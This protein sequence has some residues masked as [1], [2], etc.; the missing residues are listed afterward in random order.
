MK[1]AMLQMLPYAIWIL[2]FCLPPSRE[3]LSCTCQKFHGSTL[4]GSKRFWCHLQEGL[5]NMA[6]DEAAP[7]AAAGTTVLM[8]C[9]PVMRGALSG[10]S[11]QLRFKNGAT[12]PARFDTERQYWVGTVPEVGA[13]AA[14][15]AFL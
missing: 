6:R 13:L 12:A 10:D 9:S 2:R 14:M 3:P 7:S 15:D 1:A 11:L 5:V 8:D 4:T